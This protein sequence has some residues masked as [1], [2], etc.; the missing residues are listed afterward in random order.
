MKLITIADNRTWSPE[1]HSDCL[2]QDVVSDAVGA[3][4]ME[5]HTTTL[6]PGGVADLHS[7]P[8]SEEVFLILSGELVFFDESGQE[9]PARSGMAVFVPVGG[10]HGTINRSNKD[11]RLIAIQVPPKR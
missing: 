10:K 2:C 11:V 9:F 4:L 6:G 1:G 3:T 7:H 8:E 5:I